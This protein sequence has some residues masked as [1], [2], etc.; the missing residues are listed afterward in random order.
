MNDLFDYDNKLSNLAEHDNKNCKSC[1]EYE[2]RLI[3]Q[4]NELKTEN[5]TLKEFADKLDEEFGKNVEPTLSEKADNIIA[6]Y[7]TNK[8][9]CEIA[10]EKIKELQ[11]QL[12]QANARLNKHNEYFKSFNCIDFEEFKEFISIFMLTPHEEQTLIQD[13]KKQ[14]YQLKQQL[15]EKDKEIETQMMLFEKECQEYYKSGKYKR[16]FAI[17]EL[18]KVKNFVDGR[19]YCANYIKKRIKDLKGEKDDK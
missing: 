12:D 13:L 5:K 10:D 15:A 8:K 16:D 17:Q 7:R 11:S 2:D 1:I 18:E 19:T 14:I 3:K 6:L 4:L 9:Y